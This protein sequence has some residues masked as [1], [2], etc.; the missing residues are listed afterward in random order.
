ML[1]GRQTWF[2]FM[3]IIS[4]IVYEFY[5]PGKRQSQVV[6]WLSRVWASCLSESPSQQSRI[7]L[8]YVVVNASVLFFIMPGST[9]SE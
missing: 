7:A 4:V 5:C 2:G 1:F 3:L 8:G 9:V 6:A